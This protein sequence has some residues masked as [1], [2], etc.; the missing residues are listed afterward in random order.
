M[1]YAADV[2]RSRRAVTFAGVI[3][4]H[5]AVILLIAA[6]RHPSNVL[7][8]KPTSMTV[9]SLAKEKTAAAPPPSL[10]SKQPS[11]KK[12]V[13]V[14]SISTTPDIA[15]AEASASGCAILED[16]TKA[17]VEDPTAVSAVVQAPSDTRS[18]ADAIVMWNAEWSDP[19]ATYDGPLEPVRRAVVQSLSGLDETCLE[20][21]VIGPRF[22]PVPQGDRT[23]FLVFGSGDWKWKQLVETDNG[24]STM[25]AEKASSGQ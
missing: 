2:S 8:V 24:M 16:V 11:E 13:A 14:P 9:L 15:A 17:I 10:P 5:F 18:V 3:G 4:V 1:T 6:A 25:T 22:I 20:E 12:V 23:L 7:Q 21:P 19:T